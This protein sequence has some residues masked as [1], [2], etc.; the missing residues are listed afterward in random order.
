MVNFSLIESGTRSVAH[1]LILLLGQRARPKRPLQ[2]HLPSCVTER[3]EHPSTTPGRTL[4]PKRFFGQA[5]QLDTGPRKGPPRSRRRT[6]ASYVGPTWVL[7]SH[8]RG[9]STVWHYLHGIRFYAR[10]SQCTELDRARRPFFLVPSS[11]V[12][13]FGYRP[14]IQTCKVECELKYG[15]VAPKVLESVE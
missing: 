11:P 10:G 12:L 1:V 3:R 2:L 8:R 15:G 9:A 5:T 7:D 6:R 14:G 4:N 13:E